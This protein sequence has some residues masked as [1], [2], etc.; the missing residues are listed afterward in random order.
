MRSITSALRTYVAPFIP[1]IPPLPRQGHRLASLGFVSP[2]D[3][4]GTAGK[5]G[6]GNIYA[7]LAG[8]PSMS[9]GE[10]GSFGT[11]QEV[12][13]RYV[14]TFQWLDNYMK[15][16]G[17]HT[18]QA[19]ADY[20]YDQIDGRNYYDVNGGFGFSDSNE[21]GLGFADFLLGA[22][23][24]SFTQ[25]S[26]QI[27][28]S[29][30]NYLS[31]YLE[32]SWRAR[33]NL[34]LNYGIRYEITSPWYDTQNKIETII[35][36]EQSKVFPGA[37]LGWV[38]PGDAGVP[39]TLGPIK[40]NKFAPRFG[41]N[42][43]PTTAPAGFMSKILG[44]P[45]MFSIRGGFGL[46]YN[47]FQDESGFVEIGDAPYGLYYQASTQTMLSTPYVDRGTQHVELSK[48]PFAFPPTNVS[49]S[50]PDNNVPWASYEPLSSDYAVSPLNT[51]P[52][53][54]NYTLGVQRGIGRN[55]VLTVN[56]VGNEGRHLPNSE[57]ANP[58]NPA[59][60]L[61]LST[62][63]EVAP[64]TTACGPK[65]EGNI[66]TA[67]NGTTVLGTRILPSQNGNIAFGSNPYLLTH[68]TSNYNSLQANLKHNSRSWN[69][70][71]SYTWGRSMDNASSLT[72][73]TDVI[74]PHLS[75]GLSSYDVSQYFVGSYEV[76]L[77]LDRW[78]GNKF[79]KQVVGGWSVSGITKLATG[80]PVGISDSDDYSLTGLGDM[81]YW[82]PTTGSFILNRNPRVRNPSNP[83]QA[84]PFFNAARF[85]SEKKQFASV[86]AINGYGLR[87][88]SHHYFFHGPGSENTDAAILRDFHLFREHVVQFRMEAFDALNHA[89]FGNP[90][91]S[92]TS[93]SLGIV[94][95]SSNARQMQFGVKY[96]F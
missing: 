46:F 70:Q 17:L 35:P 57:E 44:G 21:T 83:T 14:N 20:H 60:C 82:T 61:S 43:A 55:T 59:L 24:G 76:H 11:P 27:L 13:A 16:V 79:A 32:D 7:P 39:R 90:S 66:F 68:A 91:G 77:P 26:P 1:G 78:I 63:A 18:F 33:K 62:K 2:W 81:P 3:P 10:A 41:F 69:I 95:S 75:Y 45:G 19:G 93:T 22:E 58:G 73:S 94:T 65:G 96:R 23:D 54:A 50:N 40:Y 9:I 88:N 48:F 56:Y 28:D 6:I 29:R 71:L 25:A 30:A 64:G 5:G 8:V 86:G 52:Y 42:Y 47:N 85:T 38:F 15:V 37:P 53:I 84:A 87:G 74:N 72:S 80:T 12:Q 34:S 31:G 89:N 51:V 4:V 36:G 67:A 92:A 49:P